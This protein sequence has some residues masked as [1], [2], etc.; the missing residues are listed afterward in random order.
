[1]SFRRAILPLEADGLVDDQVAADRV[2][3]GGNGERNDNTYRLSKHDAV[4]YYVLDRIAAGSPRG[5]S[6]G[7]ICL[8]RLRRCDTVCASSC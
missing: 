4:D 2:D 7:G 8:R 1:M 5:I 6:S 3:G